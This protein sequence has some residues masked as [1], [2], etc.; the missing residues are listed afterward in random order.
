M[1]IRLMTAAALLGIGAPI[2]G[3]EH[4]VDAPKAGSVAGVVIDEKSGNRVA[5]AVIILRRDE[6]GG[7]G[8]ITGADGKFALRDVDPGT[9]VLAVERDGYVIA[10]GQTQTVNVQAGQTTSDVKV[11]LLRT[12]AISGRI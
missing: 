4:Q 8:E 5:R 2:A 6:E 1:R 3:Q 11:K 10:R 9:Y 12:G 7:I